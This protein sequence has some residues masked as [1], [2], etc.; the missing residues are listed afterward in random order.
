[1]N[2]YMPKKLDKIYKFPERQSFLKLTQ[3]KIEN[4]NKERD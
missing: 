2:N 1:M 4:C 3:Y